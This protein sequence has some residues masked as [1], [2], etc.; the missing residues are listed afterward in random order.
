MSFPTPEWRSSFRRKLDDPAFAAACRSLDERAA[1]YHD[2]LPAHPERQAGYYHDFFCPEHAVQLVFDPRCGTRH[3]CPVDGA[4]FGGEPYDSAWLWSVNDLLS[5]AALRLA[6]RWLLRREAADAARAAGI[7]TGYARRYRQLPPGPKSNPRYPG[8]VTFTGLDESV[9]VIRIAWAYALVLDALDAADARLVRD[10]LLRPAAEHILRFRWPEVHNVTNW[11]NAALVALGLALGEER[12]VEAALE[13]PVGLAAELAEGVRADGLWWEISLSYH[14]YTL[15]ALVWTMRA[16][17][18]AGRPFEGDETVRRMFRAPI[19][20]AFPDLSLPALADC[21]YFIALTGAV[22]HGIPDAAGFYETAYARYRDPEFAWVLEANYSA[23]PRAS[24]EALLDGAGRIE[25]ARAPSFAS[26]VLPQSGLAAVRAGGGSS[27]LLL[28][29]GPDGGVHGHPDQLALQLFAAGTR[30]VVDL[31]TAGY[32]IEL[33]DDWYR[34]SASHATVLLDGVSQ[35]PATGRVELVRSGDDFELVRGE[36]GWREGP[37]AGV[38]SRRALLACGSYFIDYFEVVAPEPRTIDWVL[39]VRGGIVEGLEAARPRATPLEGACGYSRLASLQELDGTVARRLTWQVDGARL[40][41]H[42]PGA[43]VE[44]L[45]TASAPGN[46][47]ADRLA[48]AIRRRRAGR[49]LFVAVLVPYRAGEPRPVR[50]VRW[51]DEAVGAVEIESARGVER[52]SIAADL[53][54]VRRDV[55]PPG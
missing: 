4:V 41:L 28:R 42:L 21:W 9:W 30:L 12:F 7:L 43:P 5:D 29:A 54:S 6:A 10:E 48:L 34:Q 11:N 40:D 13:G 51:L 38:S 25:G 22:G 18:A 47:A 50:H 3:A 35:P 2:Y 24:L 55:A 17:G 1:A 32:G 53:R 49:A 16:L 23:R 27:R 44:E 26:A 14:Y 19:D 37:Y 8:V 33:N 36:V 20:L 39:G 31:G 45:I 52:W 15:A 46:P